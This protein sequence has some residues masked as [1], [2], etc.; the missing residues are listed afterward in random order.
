MSRSI[1]DLL[2]E[3]SGESFSLHE[4][5][6][7]AQMVRVLKTIGFDRQYVRAMGP[8]LY[9]DQGDRY[10]DLL[11]GFGVFAVGRNHPT[12]VRALREVMEAELPGLVQ[13]D[14]SLLSGLFAER[15]LATVPG[16]LEKAFFANSGSEAVEAA[17]KFARYATARP[18]IV[19]CDH[20][21][22]GLTLGSLSVNGEDIFREGFGPLLPDTHRVPFGDLEAL[23]RVLASHEIAAFIVEPIQGHGVNVPDASYLSEAARLCRA[24]GALF[25]ADEIQTGVG[26]TGRFWAIEHWGV[27]PDML[28]AAKALSGG[29]VPIGAV[30]LRKSV[31]DAVFSSMVRA[32]IHGST[33]SKN[34][35]AMAAG[36][37]TLE[38]I[39]QENLV[40]NAAKIGEAILDDLRAMVDRYS[41]MKEVRGLGLMQAIEFAPPDRLKHRAAWKLLDSAQKGLFAQLVTVPL[42]KRH[43][44]L[45][46]TAG[47]D[48]AVVKF[49]PPLNIDDSDRQWIARA[50]DDVIADTEKV[51]GAIWDLGR[52]LAG[53]ALRS[54]T[55]R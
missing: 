32:P 54:R 10:L 49:L 5:Y 4:Q 18:G 23:E 43:H 31:F 53:A 48:L 36:I 39:E 38:V 11:S 6:L 52:N 20:A 33:F 26:R 41:F 17:I 13:M 1:L 15:F 28:L 9:D 7:N 24:H 16:A 47:H 30:A 27:E 19:Y 3:R 45:S 14:V 37:A 40:A 8:Y 55:R 29:F 44:I 34:N 2:K 25:V 22:H 21:F 42:F 12:V 35:L 46:Q 51:G 50:V